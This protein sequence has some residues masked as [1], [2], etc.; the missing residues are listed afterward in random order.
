MDAENIGA[1][2]EMTQGTF[3]DLQ[4]AYT[5]LKMCHRHAFARQPNPSWVDLEK[6]SG[7]YAALYQR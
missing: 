4:G 2:L 6:V 1:C 7:D 5:I 3:P